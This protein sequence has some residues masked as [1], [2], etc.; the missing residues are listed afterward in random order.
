MRNDFSQAERAQL[1]RKLAF[2]LFYTDKIYKAYLL[3]EKS[4][5]YAMVLYKSNAHM[6][7][8]LRNHI[9]FLSNEEQSLAAD[10]LLHLDIWLCLWVAE[11]R[12]RKP[13]LKDPFVFENDVRFPRES[14]DELVRKLRT[15]QGCGLPT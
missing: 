9:H 14:A 11:S 3:N 2:L 10:L 13:A 15:D 6:A 5:M 7:K 8:T 1:S 4:Y 12:L